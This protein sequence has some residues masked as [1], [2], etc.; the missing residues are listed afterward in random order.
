[1]TEGQGASM[2]LPIYALYMQKVYADPT[3]GYSETESFDIPMQYA[4]P[5]QSIDYILPTDAK[6]IDKIFE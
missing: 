3:L 6:G 1:M 2:A 4:N 5:C